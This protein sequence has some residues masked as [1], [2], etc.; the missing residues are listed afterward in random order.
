[1]SLMQKKRASKEPRL[2]VISG[3]LIDL[4]EIYEKTEKGIDELTNRTYKLDYRL[5]LVLIFVDG[6]KDVGLLLDEIDK[7]ELDNASLIKL[8]RDQFISKVLPIPTL[9]AIIETPNVT[10]DPEVPSTRSISTPGEQSIHFLQA[11]KLI[12]ETVPSQSGFRG[13]RFIYKLNRAKTIEDLRS[14]YEEYYRLLTM[15][16]SVVE[17]QHWVVQLDELLARSV[18]E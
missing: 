11:C 12:R 1:M 9:R 6:R 13:M 3:Q 17:A 15:R 14:L 5:R 16:L 18:A 4:D 10:R 7:F 2:R 8:A